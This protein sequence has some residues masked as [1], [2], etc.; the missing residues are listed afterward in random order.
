M[1]IKS[2]LGF[3]CFHRVKYVNDPMQ[4]WRDNRREPLT[5][6]YDEVYQAGGSSSGTYENPVYEE[7]SGNVRADFHFPVYI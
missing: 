4:R 2:C 7:I 5:N 6:A 1:K 3:Y